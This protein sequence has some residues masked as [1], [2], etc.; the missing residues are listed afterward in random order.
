M[1]GRSARFPDAAVGLVPDFRDVLQQGA[2]HVPAGLRDGEASHA[3]LL[4]GI[5]QLAIDVEL[6]LLVGG[7]ADAHG[8]RI[9]IAGQPVDFPFGEPPLAAQSVHDLHLVGRARDGALQPVAP[10]GCLVVN[11]GV[12]HGQE[13]ERGVAQPAQAVV[14]VAR[15]AEMFGQRGRRRRHDAAGRHVDQPL[16]RDQRAPDRLGVGA[17][18]LRR[19]SPVA[20]EGLAVL[21]RLFRVDRCRHVEMRGTVAQHERHGLALGEGK[22]RHGLEVLAA[23][24]RWRAQD[25]HVGA[26]HGAHRA[27]VEPRHPGSRGAVA[28]AQHQLHADL[29]LALVAAHDADQVGRLAVRR[30]EVDQSDRA[31]IGLEGGLEDQGIGPIAAP[32]GPDVLVRRDQPEAVALAA[33]QRGE[34]GV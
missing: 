25:G 33:Q 15:A 8:F 31:A 12:H 22:Q 14:P 2:L 21:Q 20:P 9:G 29:H 4:E 5:H 27:V 17:L 7:V 16:E 13:R 23:E 1:A 28:E 6:E 30:H 32:G 19:R 26:G 10:G 11:T 34:A 3:R 24:R 18:A